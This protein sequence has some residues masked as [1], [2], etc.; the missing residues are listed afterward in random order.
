[1]KHI[2]PKIIFELSE[3][4]SSHGKE[5]FV[6]G[7]SVRDFSLGLEPKDYDLCTNATPDQTIEICSA[8][9]TQ[10]QGK[11]FAVVAIYDEDNVMYEIASYRRDINHTGR[12]CQV[13][14]VSSLEEDLNRRD[15]TINA[16]CYDIK[17]DKIIDLVG[18][19]KDLENKVIRFIGDPSERI[20]EDKLRILRM[21]RFASR[22]N[23]FIDIKS[24]YAAKNS[25]LEEVSQKRIID[26]FKAAYKTSED[27]SMFLHLISICDM[28]GQVF[29]YTIAKTDTISIS[30]SS[31]FEI[32]IANLLKPY[33][34]NGV[35]KNFLIQ[36]IKFD[37]RTAEIICLLIDLLDFDINKLLQYHKKRKTFEVSDEML[38][39]WFCKNKKDNDVK[40][41]KFLK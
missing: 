15:F 30:K 17:N 8:Y 41:K 21:F 24:L 36:K 33:T 35:F 7:G 13:E 12:S 9:R 14:L 19:L 34:P 5:L 28:W 1:M 38:H 31:F 29:H 39:E 18:G 11:A 26:E 23:F 40:Y 32:Y 25:D 10:L 16:L 4:F 22:L 37:A 3:L 27:F 20:K 2:L 6:V